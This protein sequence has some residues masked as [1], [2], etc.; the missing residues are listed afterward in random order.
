MEKPTA[1][2]LTKRQWREWPRCL[3]LSRVGQPLQGR[4]DEIW[5]QRGSPGLVL[6]DA[7]WQQVP[8]V[9]LVHVEKEVFRYFPTLLRVIQ[10]QRREIRLNLKY[11]RVGRCEQ[12]KHTRQWKDYCQ[13]C[14]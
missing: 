11:G 2:Q 1:H 9:G 13:C 12:R 10:A 6:G 7:L 5:Q 3:Y 8:D 14:W 4:V